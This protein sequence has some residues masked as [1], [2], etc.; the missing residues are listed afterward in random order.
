[1]KIK[2]YL[3]CVVLILVGVWSSITL[4]QKVTASSYVNGDI[5]I[6]NQF[7]QESFNYT[8]SQVT[9]YPS[10]NSESFVFETDLIKVDGFDSTL[11]EYRLSFNDEPVLDVEFT[12]GAVNGNVYKN[13]YATDGTIEY[14]ANLNI[15][16]RFLSGKT[17]LVLS[18]DSFESATYFE[19]FFSDY[20]IRL[21]VE[22]IF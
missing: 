11:K 3:L 19:Q 15:V 10:E 1:M 13:F 16:I 7:S 4:Y 17:Q 20:G 5:D 22:E 21:I 18:T 8:N 2:Y 9:F 14:S 6:S 12:A